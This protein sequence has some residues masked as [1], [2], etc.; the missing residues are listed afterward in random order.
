MVLLPLFSYLLR[1]WCAPR[2]SAAARGPLALVAHQV[3]YDLLASFRNPRARFFTFIFPVVLLVI[4]AGVFG[5][6]HTVILG[7]RVKLARFYVP[8]I[9]AMSIIAAAYTN[10]VISL[11]ALRAA[12]VLKRRRATPVSPAALVAGQALTT[13]VIALVMSAILLLLGG[14][15]YGVG[16][17]LGALAALACT[18]I[19]G[20]LATAAV[21]YLVAGLIAN[22]DA[23]Q[24]VV[25]LT[26]LPLYFIS[27]VFIP[28]ASLTPALRDIARVF[29]VERLADA[30]QRAALHGSFTAAVS[31]GDLLVLAIWGAAA[32]TLAARR[33]SWMPSTAGG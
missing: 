19:V 11:S 22:P 27:S 15:A 26:T 7:V 31:P 32:A 10:L 25:Q 14:L 29:P 8:G 30:F 16:F 12:G 18:V 2:A 28:E 17:S 4:L 6:G 20:T 24:P 1:R 13:L 23:A 9:L 3:R 33:F 21:G 5:S